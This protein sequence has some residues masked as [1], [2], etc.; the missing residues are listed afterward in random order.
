MNVPSN[1][2]ADTPPSET[3]L[4]PPKQTDYDATEAGSH[5]ETSQSSENEAFGGKCTYKPSNRFFAFMNRIVPHGGAISN[6]YNLASV[7]IGSGIL[8]LP[9]SFQATGIIFAIVMLVLVTLSTAYSTFILGQAAEKTKFKLYTYEL[10]SK[11]LLGHGCDYLAAFI[12]WMFCFGSCVSYVISVGDIIEN[13]TQNSTSSSFWTTIWG[14]RLLVFIVWA[15]LMLPLAIPKEINSLR[16]VSV[17]SVLS[18]VYFVAVIVIHACTNAFEN[19]KLKH[20]VSLFKWGNDATSGIGTFIFSF[21]CQTNTF[22]VLREMNHPTPARL[23][24]D[25]SFSMS[26]CC[27]LY[28]IAGL[29]GYLDFGE[30]IDDSILLFYDAKREPMVFISYFGIGLKLCVSFALCMLPARDSLYYCLSKKFPTF[31]SINTVPF[32][33]NAAI[34]AAMSTLALL[35]GTLG[36]HVNVVFNLLGGLCGGFIGFIFPAL[37]IMYLGGWTLKNVGWF[38]YLSTYILLMLGVL[39]VVL[40]TTT[41]IYSMIV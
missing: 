37:F 17:I 10:L 15:C 5:T 38:H 39:A 11:G 32:W 29:F 34:C 12:M 22:E 36:I 8:S 24:R 28:I 6:S 18:M 14:N 1:D 25:T 23:T 40:G 4:S 30:S 35:L 3:V 19:G 41:T 21:V 16:Y 2:R 9:S 13:I 26:A 20:K 33:R 31:K 27:L 7:T